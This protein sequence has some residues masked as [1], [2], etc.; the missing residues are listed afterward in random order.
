MFKYLFLSLALVSCIVNAGYQ[1]KDQSELARTADI[2]GNKFYL[3]S[4][5]LGPQ[6]TTVEPVCHDRNQM[7][8]MPYDATGIVIG[9]WWKIGGQVFGYSPE[10]G[11]TRFNMDL[12]MVNDNFTGQTPKGF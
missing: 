11:V 4:D 7:F 3:Y 6:F 12:L 2:I 5:N 8:V 10:T 1:G 9:C